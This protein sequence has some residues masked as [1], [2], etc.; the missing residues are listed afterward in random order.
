MSHYQC[1]QPGLR[2]LQI[3]FLSHCFIRLRISYKWNC[4]SFSCDSV[5]VFIGSSFLFICVQNFLYGNTYY[6]LQNNIFMK[7]QLFLL[8][9][10]QEYSFCEHLCTSFF[11]GTC[12]YLSKYLSIGF[13]QLNSVFNFLT[14]GLFKSIFCLISKYLVIFPCIFYLLILV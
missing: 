11:V 3:Y 6:N 12:F 10:W 2:Q 9:V 1:P 4:A 13:S 14:L 8:W 7:I 5:F